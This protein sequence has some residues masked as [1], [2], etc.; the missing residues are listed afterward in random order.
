MSLLNIKAGQ[1]VELDFLQL[2]MGGVILACDRSVVCIGVC[3]Y[4]QTSTDLVLLFGTPSI[5]ADNPR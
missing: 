1:G 2:N 5:Q 4:K 3:N